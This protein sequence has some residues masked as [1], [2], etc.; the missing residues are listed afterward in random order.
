[1]VTAK[2]IAL[3][4]A[5]LMLVSCTPQPRIASV[6]VVREPVVDHFELA[7]TAYS[8]D[9]LEGALEH[10]D[11][12]LKN[13]PDGGKAAAALMKKGAVLRAMGRGGEALSAFD[14]LISRFPESPFTADA[15]VESMDL[16]LGMGAYGE[17]FQKAG[18][19]M[20]MVSSYPHLFRISL[21]EGDA[22][23]ATGAHVDAVRAYARCRTFG[24]DL[25]VDARIGETVTLLEREGLEEL[26]DEL[27]D[28]VA[29]G[30][31]LY[32]LGM[33]YRELGWTA[34]ALAVLQR[35]T[36]EYPE[37]ENGI[38]AEEEIARLMEPSDFHPY[39]VGC[40]LPLSGKYGKIGRRAL[41][42]LEMAVGLSASGEFPFRVV[43]RDTASDPQR[44]LAVVDELAEEGVSAIVGPIVTALDVAEKVQEMGIPMVVLTQKPNITEVG[45]CIFR[46][47]LTPRMQVETIVNHLM[48]ELGLSRFAILY[49]EENYGRTFMNL[50]WDEVIRRGGT[51]VGVESYDGGNTDFGDPIKKLVGLYYPIPRDLRDKESRMVVG[52]GS[53][54]MKKKELEPIVD[55]DAVFIPDAPSKAG[56]ILPQF[57]FYDVNQV[58][59]A[60]TNLWHSRKL[61]KMAGK[62][63]RRAVIPEGFFAGSSAPA[64]VNFMKTFTEIYGE[65]PGYMEAVTYDSAMMLFEVLGRPGMV[66]TADIIRE[67]STLSDFRGVTGTTSFGGTGDAGKELYLLKVDKGRFVDA[68]SQAM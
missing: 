47:F 30:D 65:T 54:G 4:A 5:L 60:G 52:E 57:S 32:R 2:R 20:E 42:G 7:E 46:N 62:E 38:E 45:N 21:M 6:P 43:I 58:Y 13:S 67:L 51:V 50:F 61:V 10:Y 41:R 56:L 22:L 68:R 39:T 1:M 12:Y 14:E 28:P 64:V 35:F 40:L 49:P 19:L 11:R 34:E 3:L 37:H 33:S 29:L 53:R 66:S 36:R 26:V 23:N 24:D 8:L 55:F 15:G 17:L 59:F 16:L 44:A 9:N 18:V 63:V 31:L 48:T 27:S 25:A